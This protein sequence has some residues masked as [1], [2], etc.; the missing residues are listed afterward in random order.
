MA[1]ICCS[2]ATTRLNVTDDLKVFLGGRVVNYTLTGTTNTYRESGL[3]G[4]LYEFE[5]GPSP[6]SSLVFFAY[7]YRFESF[8]SSSFKSCPVPSA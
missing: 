1:F 6:F 2:I 4:M 7:F 3:C 8:Y 5:H